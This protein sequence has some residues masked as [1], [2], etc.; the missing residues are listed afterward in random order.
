MLCV[1]FLYCCIYECTIVVY[2]SILTLPPHWLWFQRPE[3]G[4]FSFFL[5]IWPA[6]LLVKS[7]QSVCSLHERHKGQFGPTVPP[8]ASTAAME[9]GLWSGGTDGG[10]EKAGLED[11][12]QTLWAA[13]S[14]W[15]CLPG[16]LSS[17]TLFSLSVTHFVLPPLCSHTTDCVRRPQCRHIPASSSHEWN[18]IFLYYTK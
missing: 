9:A 3:T 7:K 12:S 8:S 17:T 4:M 14:C 15:D 2:S 11:W 16:L 10:R 5:S 13:L 1:C 18:F 6:G